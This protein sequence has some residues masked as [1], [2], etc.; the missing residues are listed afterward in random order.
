MARRKDLEEIL[1]PGG[2]RRGVMH[3]L[4]HAVHMMDS[5]LLSEREAKALER[6]FSSE[7]LDSL[8]GD[9]LDRAMADGEVDRLQ[10]RGGYDDGEDQDEADGFRYKTAVKVIV[11]FFADAAQRDLIEP[12][13]ALEVIGEYLDLSEIDADPV[14]LIHGLI[15]TIHEKSEEKTAPE[16]SGDEQLADYM[17]RYDRLGTRRRE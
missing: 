8:H 10:A 13:Q 17:N 4:R 1:W 12:E 7:I 11:H 16:K 3:A 2:Q 15:D 6:Y 14:D 5:G 9:E